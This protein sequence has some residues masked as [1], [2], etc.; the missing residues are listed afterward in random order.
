MSSPLFTG[1]TAANYAAKHEIP[2]AALKSDLRACRPEIIGPDAPSDPFPIPL[3]GL[4]QKGFGRGGKDLGC[5]TGSYFPCSLVMVLIDMIAANLPD[6]SIA[7]LSTKV[8]MGVYYGYAQVIP[9]QEKRADFAPEDLGVLPMVMSLGWNPFYK[10]E[11][12]TAVR[13]I[14]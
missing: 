13:F 10:N 6:Q 11:K 3:A 2:P 8:E 12:L 5:P 14:H 7:P 4:V 9:P 1:T